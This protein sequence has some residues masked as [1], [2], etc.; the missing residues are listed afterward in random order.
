MLERPTLILSG[1]DIAEI[2]VYFDIARANG[3]YLHLKETISLLYPDASEQEFL[4]AWRKA[5]TLSERFEIRSGLILSKNEC[6]TESME[7]YVEDRR[8]QADRNLKHAAMFVRLDGSQDV[9]VFSVSGSTSYGSASKQ[10]DLD[11]FC[12]TQKD[13][14]WLFLT[15]SL[16]LARVFRFLNGDSPDL[17]FCCNMDEGYAEQLFNERKDALF[18][19]DALKVCVIQGSR[20][21]NNLL[22]INSWISKYSPELYRTK[23]D[24]N[25]IATTSPSN[26]EPNIIMKV[27]NLFLYSTIGNYLRLKA[28]LRKRKL[29]REGVGRRLVSYKIGKDCCIYESAHYMQLRLM[30][31]HL[32]K[33]EDA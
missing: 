2:Q 27:A 17:C 24:P 19:R 33:I 28:N 18:A 11:F 26:Q 25:A 29:A 8:R 12:I 14:L 16:L 20:F 7:S 6:M 31:A 10:D 22:Q 4:E 13:S 5:S 23:V 15:R 9:R 21:Y 1:R 30:Y 32:D 3:T